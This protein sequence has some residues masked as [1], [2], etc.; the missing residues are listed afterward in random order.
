MN[1]KLKNF[2]SQILATSKSERNHSLIDIIEETIKKSQSSVVGFV[3][4]QDCDNSEVSFPSYAV[5]LIYP[6]CRSNTVP[7]LQTLCLSKIK[8]KV[9]QSNIHS[10]PL[11]AKIKEY[12][13]DN[14][15]TL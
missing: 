8:S 14:Y 4:P 5:R 10:L 3:L 11:P 15:N 13:H 9:N 7:T 12:V 1:H 2:R 6:I